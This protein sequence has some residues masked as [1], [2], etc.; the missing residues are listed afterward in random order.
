VRV[1]SQLKRELTDYANSRRVSITDLLI[2]AL[3]L[4]QRKHVP[5]SL[6]LSRDYGRY[7]SGKRPRLVAQGR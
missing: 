6:T 4:L 7:P 3:G 1:S 2:E 5:V